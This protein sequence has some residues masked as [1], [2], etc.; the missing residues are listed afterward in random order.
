M[1]SLLTE[2]QNNTSKKSGSK[3]DCTQK[4]NRTLR[5]ESENNLCNIFAW[6][7]H[8][9][10]PHHHLL[11]GIFQIILTSYINIFS[12]F[13]LVCHVQGKPACLIYQ[14]NDQKTKI[15]LANIRS[16]IRRRKEAEKLQMQLSQRVS[17][18]LCHNLLPGQF[19]FVS[20][21]KITV[22]VLLLL[23]SVC[24]KP[25]QYRDK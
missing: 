17:T 8:V 7:L 14:G 4:K 5:P 22:H 12:L 21:Q 19:V 9:I 2:K 1:Q 16:N 10:K 23:Y 25:V 6:R 13:W 20:A 15:T 24:I 3:K 11:H 18:V